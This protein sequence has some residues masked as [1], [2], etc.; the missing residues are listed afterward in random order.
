MGLLDA[1]AP[2][3]SKAGRERLSNQNAA[4]LMGWRA[5]LANR[6]FA[7]A[8][9]VCLGD[10]ITE[11]QGATTMDRR[12]VA[13]L[14]KRLRTRFPVTGIT[15]GRGFIGSD[16][17]GVSSY[18]W[19]VTAAGTVTVDDNYG[20]KRRA[21]LM[22]ATGQS[23]TF[24]LQGTSVDIMY[25]RS[26]ATGILYYKI[27]GGSAVTINTATG[28]TQGTQV[29]GGVIANVVL[30][31]SGAHTLEVGWS[32]GGTVYLEGVTEYDGDEAAGIR[33][34]DAGHHGWTTTNWANRNGF[35]Y[36]M[37]SIKT[38]N[39]DL[40]VM[41]LGTN[42]LTGSISAATT[43]ANWQAILGYLRGVGCDP[44]VLIV[45]MFKRSEG[46]VT[47][48]IWDPY[49]SAAY[50]L[51]AGDPKVAIAD[52]GAKMPYVGLGTP[53]L[54]LYTDTVHPTDK[55]HSMMADLILGAITP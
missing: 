52:I 43:L 15:G 46:A 21:A 29:V 36:W 10:S 17:T 41:P 45:P 40:L 47:Q 32:S 23:R 42:D 20:P 50:Q 55:G 35:F 37:Q 7:P 11:G 33:V 13:Q 22:T 54:S 53:S 9:V 48:A 18:T 27:D 49:V 16:K 3:L 14:R 24:T 1:P 19:P 4:A 31:A 38:L 30:G 34:H 44:S 28:Y 25:G 12:Y 26:S 2:T 8:V 6:E 5:G 51:A 39:P